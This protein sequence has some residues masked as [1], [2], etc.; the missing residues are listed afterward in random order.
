MATTR[1]EWLVRDGLKGK[2]WNPITGCSKISA[3]C[4]NCYAERMSKRLRGRYGYDAE[5]PFKVTLHKNRIDEPLRWKKPQKVFVCSMG[6]LFHN[7]VEDW[8]LDK[9]FGVILGC[10]IFNNTPDHI[11]M[12]LTKRPERMCSYLTNKTPVELLKTWANACPW[13]PDDPDITVEDLI[14]SATCRDWDEQGRNSSGSEYKPWG[15]INKLWPLPNVWLGVTAENQEMAD[16]RIPI[17][18]QIPAA[19][20]FV[21]VEPM[22]GPVDLTQLRIDQ[23][24]HCE[25]HNALTDISTDTPYGYIKHD[26]PDPLG[27]GKLDWVICGYESGPKRRPAQIEWVRDLRSQCV[28]ANIPFFLKQIEINAQMV[29]M[30]ELDGKVWNQMP[31]VARNKQ[32]ISY[33]EV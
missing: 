14:Y 9:I 33:V 16:E 7:D 32:A 25:H 11:F 2:T 13:Y 31:E 18:L 6:D 10:K 26:V 1:I 4:N 27:R 12:I 21:S 15:Y 3:G 8:M 5:N 28:T 17:L 24:P 22:L 23:E 30:P 29:K 20:R 19:V